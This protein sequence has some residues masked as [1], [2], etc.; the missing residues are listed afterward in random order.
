MTM[1]AAGR[2]RRKGRS[3]KSSNEKYVSV[4]VAQLKQDKSMGAATV[5]ELKRGVQ[6]K[7]VDPGDGRWLKVALAKNPGT[8]GWIYFNKVV[9]K[10]P[11][12]IGTHLA[13]GGG[14]QTS[15]LETGGAIRGLKKASQSYAKKM[16]IKPWSVADLHRI[17]TFPLSLKDFDKNRNGNLDAVELKNANEAYKS[18]I[19]G[20]IEAFLKEGK[21]G[22][23]AQ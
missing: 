20:K 9:A 12:D 21:L 13:L 15:D 18:W 16:K 14:I 4:P 2:R 17:Q 19:E 8:A 1:D 11:K 10:K 3:K 6:L 7:V 5:A 23:Y 22:E